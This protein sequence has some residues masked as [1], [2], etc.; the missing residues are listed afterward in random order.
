MSMVN[1]QCSCTRTSQVEPCAVGPQACQAGSGS[2]SSDSNG[3]TRC[4]KSG[5]SMQSMSGFI[6]GQFV[7]TC[8]CTQP[9]N[10]FFS[11]G[12][13]IIQGGDPNFNATAFDES[14]REWSQS[15][16][17]S[18]ASSLQGIAHTLGNVFAG[19]RL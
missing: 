9:L 19:F 6:N 11:S 3:R 7:E 10:G 17:Q 16:G 18:L 1:M 15:F 5:W 8:T 13:Q 2:F 4:C 14:M 12:M